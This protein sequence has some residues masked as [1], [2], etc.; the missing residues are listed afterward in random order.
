MS[1]IGLPQICWNEN[2]S[3][4]YIAFWNFWFRFRSNHIVISINFLGDCPSTIC[5]DF[6]SK[7]I[8]PWNI[9]SDHGAVSIKTSSVACIIQR[10]LDSVR[11]IY[12]PC[13]K[14]RYEEKKSGKHVNLSLSSQ[15][16]WTEASFLF[17]VY[18]NNRSNIVFF[19]C[20]RVSFLKFEDFC[21]MVE[22]KTRGNCLSNVVKQK[23][24][25]TV[26]HTVSVSATIVL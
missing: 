5:L 6:V 12:G 17:L 8:H 2:T 24:K 25:N 20:L 3:S 13:K 7:I 16:L 9:V 19:V 1:I 26:V 10:L 15:N 11:S 14:E 18:E 22:E 21:F 23:N 4:T